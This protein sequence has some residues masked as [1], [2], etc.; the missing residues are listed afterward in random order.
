MIMYKETKFTMF[1]LGDFFQLIVK[2]KQTEKDN[3]HGFL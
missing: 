2:H 1:H 3:N